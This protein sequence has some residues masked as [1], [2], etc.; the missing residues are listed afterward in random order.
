M[1]LRAV[2]TVVLAVA[3]LVVTAWAIVA[4]I[5]VLKRLCRGEMAGLR[6]STEV[7]VVSCGGR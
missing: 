6:R 4:R 1:L 3:L 5:A 2:G 7:H